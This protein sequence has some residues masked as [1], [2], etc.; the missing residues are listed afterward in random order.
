MEVLSYKRARVH[1]NFKSEDL[2]LKLK[3]CTKIHFNRQIFI[4]IFI[5]PSVCDSG[6]RE[7]EVTSHAEIDLM[8]LLFFIFYIIFILTYLQHLIS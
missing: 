8:S 6:F 2:I 5:I 1:N 7:G 4:H 3:V